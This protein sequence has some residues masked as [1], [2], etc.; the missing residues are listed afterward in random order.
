[1]N[2]LHFIEITAEV[3]G[4]AILVAASEIAVIREADVSPGY[5]RAI[6]TLK[7]G[8]I[9]ATATD[10]AEVVKRLAHLTKPTEG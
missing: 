5:A 3:G 8:A 10:Y 7:S 2:M 9:V 6:L 1:M 4:L